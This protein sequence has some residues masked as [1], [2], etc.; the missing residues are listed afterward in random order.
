VVNEAAG[1]RRMLA[2]AV[3]APGQEG[4]VEQIDRA[5]DELKPDSWKGYTV[6]DP[7]SPSKHPWR[8]DD[9]KLMYPVY[10]KMVK[11]GITKICIH[12]GLLPNDYLQSFP[13]W[14]YAT[15]DD[16]PK[17]AK[18]WPDLA[19]IIYHSALKPINE[20][21]EA[22]LEKFRRT[23]RIDWVSDLAEIPGKHGVTNVYAEVGTAFASCAVAHP[24]HA[25]A[26]L[27]ILIKG[28]GVDHV[29]WGTDSVWY[30]SPQWQIEAFRR[31]EIPEDMQEEYG[32]QPLGGDRSEVKTAILWDNGARFYGIDQKTAAKVQEDR[33]ADA[34]NQSEQERNAFLGEL[35]YR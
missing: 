12:K 28:M 20:Y 16:L 23:G 14:R 27:G 31:L 1:S 3:I 19:F 10:D 21:P 11:S 33:I 24:R 18:D 6:G 35:V 5:I 32:F 9:E 17:A 26:L 29:L 4:W 34:K 15:V 22:H 25:A 8:L 7:L 2:H 13:A 30:G